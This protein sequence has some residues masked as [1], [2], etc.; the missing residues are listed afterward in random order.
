MCIK[1]SQYVKDAQW[2]L[3]NTIQYAR[4]PPILK[5]RFSI[6]LM[7]SNIRE[8]VV[9]TAPPLTNSLIKCIKHSYY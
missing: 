6:V 8:Q 9:H 5:I 7:P 4:G 3:K 1:L 2:T